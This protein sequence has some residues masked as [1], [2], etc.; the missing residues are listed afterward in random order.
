MPQNLPMSQKRRRQSISATGMI[1]KPGVVQSINRSI[2]PDKF[3]LKG[4][5]KDAKD[6]EEIVLQKQKQAK[7]VKKAETSRL[8]DFRR[9]QYAA[10]RIQKAW[11]NHKMRSFAILLTAKQAVHK[12]RLRQGAEEFHK[13][14]AALTIQLAWRKYIRKKLLQSLHPNKR[15]LRMWDPELIALKQRALVSQIYGEHIEA[16]FWHPNMLRPQRPYWARLAPSS[17]GQLSLIK[18]QDSRSQSRNYSYN[19]R[20]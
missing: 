1:N 3:R 12:M 7:N 20:R 2:S 11:R 13:Q 9:K 14:I 10:M 16:P 5:K 18:L 15:Q 6:E 19:M 8:H 17:A 4:S